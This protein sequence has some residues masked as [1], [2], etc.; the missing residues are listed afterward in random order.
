MKTFKKIISVG[1][2][3]TFVLSAFAS[4]ANKDDNTKKPASTGTYTFEVNT[5]APETTAAPTTDAA[6]EGGNG[7]LI[8][9]IA[10]VVAVAV[11]AVV[12]VIVIK[13]KKAE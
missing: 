13:K 9:I 4:C 11:I 1:L 2:A 3:A 7:A 6:E 8:G 10:A 12:V 5:K